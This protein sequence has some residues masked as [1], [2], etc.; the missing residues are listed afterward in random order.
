MTD[1]PSRNIYLTGSLAAVFVKTAA[2]IILMMLVNGSFNLV[3]A[4]FLGIF[5]GADAL[6]AV[7]SMFPAFMLLTAL[8][9]LVANGFSSVMARQLGAGEVAAAKDTFAQA[10]TLSLGV[11]A[12]L[13]IVFFVS[14]SSLTLFANNGDTHLASM[15]YR[16]IS[17]LI[18]CSPL[19]FILAIN[20]DSFRC[21]GHV[22]FM[23]LISLLSVL[24][25]GIFNYVLIVKL[26]AGVAGSAIGTVLAQFTALFVAFAFRRSQ[27]NHLKMPV[28]A[29]TNGRH[30][31][32]TFFALGAPSSLSYLG[33]ALSSAAILFNLQLIDSPNY[34]ITVGAYGIVT[35]LST[36]IFLPLLGLS[37]A[38]QSI[39][40]NNAG[41]RELKRT[42][43]SLKIAIL[44]AFI[45]CISIQGL[46]WLLKDQIGGWFVEEVMVM[47]EVSRILPLMTLALFLMGPLMM[48]SMLFQALG[49]AARAGLLS[50]SKTY[51]FALPL[52]FILPH[53]LDEQGIWLAGP[54]AEVLALLLTIVVLYQRARQHN[55]RFGLFFAAEHR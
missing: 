44:G 53:L 52:V 49:D 14:G 18:F 10:I 21:E 41:A 29:V 55:Y 7:T 23:A 36:F 1:Q 13:I 54:S 33:V 48:I 30:Q 8:S 34:A 3:D 17:I 27:H 51:V 24:L 28:I 15:S 2:P 38:F 32:R 31:W 22:G 6:T 50:L 12:V 46:I 26:N 42:N 19:A 35:R 16:Y 11:C 25:N 43:S 5:V 37:M 45:Y 4:Y 9:T 40:G 39:A 20:G 47:Q